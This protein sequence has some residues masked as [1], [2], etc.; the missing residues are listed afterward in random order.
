MEVE[1][2]NRDDPQSMSQFGALDNPSNVA[3]TSAFGNT[4]QSSFGNM[5]Q[6]N[7]A[8]NILG[9]TQLAGQTS[10]FGNAQQNQP[11]NSLFGNTNPGPMTGNSL[12]AGTNTN[13]ATQSSGMNVDM[14]STDNTQINP[15]GFVPILPS[16]MNQSSAT[17]ANIFGNAQNQSASTSPFGN[18]TTTN[19]QPNTGLLGNTNTLQSATGGNLFGNATMNQPATG[20]T[21][22]TI[23]QAAAGGNV[24]GNPS[25]MST[26]PPGSSSTTN[27]Q[28]NSLFGNAPA[29]NQP[30]NGLF[31]NTSTTSQPTASNAAQSISLFGNTGTTQQQQPLFGDKPGNLFGSTNTGTTSGTGFFPSTQQPQQPNQLSLFGSANVTQPGSLF[32]NTQNNVTGNGLFGDRSEGTL[33]G[34]TA[35][36]NNPFNTSTLSSSFLGTKTPAQQQ[37]IAQAQAVQL[38]Q[39]IEAIYN[40]WN[41]NSPQCK[42]QVCSN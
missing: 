37:A 41:P 6:Q 40:A 7:P 14:G 4:Q 13:N 32:G 19:A 38:Q 16:N 29:T 33:F 20:N 26:Q 21:S 3:S 24:F 1:F 39:K 36:S 10:V 17:G 31:G 5:Q 12:L 35:R 22:N 30:A 8:G 25:T 15:A 27:Q 9:N 34:N 42:F 2:A 11:T 18:T 23:P 28:T